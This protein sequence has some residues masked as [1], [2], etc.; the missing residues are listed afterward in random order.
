MDKQTQVALIN[1]W[2]NFNFFSFFP[3]ELTAARNP[4][5]NAVEVHK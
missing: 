5:T 2:E 1:D 3:L 4:Y